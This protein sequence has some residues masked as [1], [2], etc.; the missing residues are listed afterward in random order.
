MCSSDLNLRALANEFQFHSLGAYTTAM[1]ISFS[2]MSICLGLATSAQVSYEPAVPIGA[3][4]SGIERA[5]VAE[6]DGD[7]GMEVILGSASTGDVLS[8][9][10][11][12]GIV[13]G[14]TRLLQ[15][16]ILRGAFH[17][18]DLNGDGRADLVTG[19]SGDY[20]FFSPYCLSVYLSDGGGGYEA[21]ICAFVGASYNQLTNAD[22]VGD[23]RQELIGW[24]TASVDIYTMDGSNTAM[25]LVRSISGNQGQ[26]PFTADL[27]NDGRAELILR[28]LGE[29]IQVWDPTTGTSAPLITIGTNPLYVASTIR[30][31]D[32]DQDGWVDLVQLTDSIG[33]DNGLIVW[34]NLGGLLFQRQA[35]ALLDPFIGNF[36]VEDL[37]GNGI[38]NVVFTRGAYLKHAEFFPDFIFS[39]IDTLLVMPKGIGPFSFVDLDQDGPLDLLVMSM[40]DRL[41]FAS[42]TLDTLNF[43]VLDTLVRWSHRRIGAMVPIDPDVDGMQELALFTNDASTTL[44]V[45]EPDPQAWLGMPDEVEFDPNEWGFYGPLLIVT[46]LDAD[47]DEDM[48]G[49]QRAT[50]PF[51]EQY[52][53]ALENIAGHY[54]LHPLG[55]VMAPDAMYRRYLFG[56]MALFDV[57]GD[58]L[59]D[60]VV[61]GSWQELSG[62]QSETPQDYILLRTAPFAVEE[63]TGQLSPAQYLNGHDMDQDGDVDVIELDQQAGVFIVHVNDGNGQFILADPVQADLD[64]LLGSWSWA[65]VDGD[66][67]D[68][69]VRRAVGPDGQNLYSQQTSG[70]ALGPPQLF[71]EAQTGAVLTRY[72]FTDLDGDHDADLLTSS[73]LEPG[74]YIDVLSMHLNSNGSATSIGQAIHTGR[75][76]WVVPFDMDADGDLDIAFTQTASIYVLRQLSGP[77]AVVEEQQ[78]TSEDAMLY[79]NPCD[80]SVMIDLGGQPPAGAYAE[81][82]DAFGRNVERFKLTTNLSRCDVSSLPTG[83]YVIHIVDGADGTSDRAGRLV[84]MRT[85]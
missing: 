28:T 31:A 78:P 44:H 69:M 76:D 48:V 7:P 4:V 13:T 23:S 52:L 49:Y 81:V 22:L 80:Q 19:N 70:L 32:I 24:R 68:E 8:L 62:G 5:F 12:D 29:A 79:P 85:R 57:N 38:M 39:D 3:N 33:P 67:K 50:G 36:I 35:I 30:P 40:D 34:R 61:T 66:E 14:Y 75:W 18:A 17:T 26:T 72:Q 82:V 83:T 77:D 20:P 37:D 71:F 74:S 16:E 56:S 43:P 25:E 1:K 6:V 55:T 42:G 21:P 64:L 63:G 47:G 73:E 51:N 15:G 10:L 11:Q 53:F 46:D 45:M 2:G 41:C 9:D 65:D 27:T 59:S 84:I 58:G 54:T 60:L